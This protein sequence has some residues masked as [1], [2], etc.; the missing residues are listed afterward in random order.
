MIE[1]YGGF[2]FGQTVA[3]DLL[4]NHQVLTHGQRFRRGD[5]ARLLVAGFLERGGIQE[6]VPLDPAR[7]VKQLFP[8]RGE[9]NERFEHLGHGMYRFIGQDSGSVSGPTAVSPHGA[10]ADALTPDHV[11][12]KGTYE[13]YAWCLPQD[14]GTGDHWSIKIGYAGEGGFCR[15]WQQDFATH[16]PVRPRYLRSFRHETEAKARNTERYLHDM[17]G[18]EGRRRRVQDVPGTEWFLTSPDEIDQLMRHRSP[19]LFS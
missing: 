3:K 1:S 2:R 19:H 17:L 6:E 15:R 7:T 11:R 13:V 16:L 14:E 9:S 5:I 4:D 8:G 18:D 12:G 10:G